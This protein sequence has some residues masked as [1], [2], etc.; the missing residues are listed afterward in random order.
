MP[1]STP[2]IRTLATAPF[3]HVLYVDGGSNNV[4]RRATPGKNEAWGS[5][6]WGDGSDAIALD[7]QSD[8]PIRYEALARV[9]R[10]VLIASSNDVKFQNNNY[11][12]LLAMLYALRLAT[13]HKSEVKWIASDS[14]LI[15]DYWSL[16]RVAA[17][18]KQRMDRAK[19]LALDETVT[20]RREFERRGGALVKIPGSKNPADLG[21]HK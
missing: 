15:I 14:R 20:L 1:P 17:A 8:L 10:N 19:R 13:R 3:R 5:V 2:L 16:G 4:T 18:T 11:A 6:V 12:E 9:S 21:Y 7:P